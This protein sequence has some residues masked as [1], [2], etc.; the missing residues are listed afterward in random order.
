MIGNVVSHGRS[1]RDAR[2]LSA[3][4]LKTEQNERVA[5]R[6]DN[7]LATDLPASLRDMQLMRDGTRADA[8]FLHIS[9][10]PGRQMTDA[11][12]HRAGDIVLRHL[13][14][15]EHGCAR[16]LHDKPRVG[17]EG[18]THLHLVVARVGP[19]GLVVRAGLDKIRVETACRLAE[20]ELGE[21]PTLGRH[22]PSALRFFEKNRPEVAAWL[23]AG[24]GSQPER[25][26]SAVTPDQ[27]RVLDRKQID[28]RDVRETVRLALSQ[29]DGPQALRAALGEAGLS[30]VAGDKAG[31]WIVQR[32][33]EFV[34]ALDRLAKQKRAEVSAFM[35]KQHV[36]APAPS[37]APARD[38]RH[39]LGPDQ[40]GGPG[41]VP[42]ARPRPDAGTG[43]AAG[44]PGRS[45]REPGAG[46]LGAGAAGA[47]LPDRDAAPDRRPARR[48]RNAAVEVARAD[49]QPRARDLRAAAARIAAQASPAYADAMA[50]LDRRAEAARQRMA[51]ASVPLEPPAS[52]AEARKKADK[53]RKAALDAE[54]RE[55]EAKA[56]LAAA[57][58]SRPRGVLAWVTGKVAVADRQI[59]ALEKLA[60]ERTQDARTRR[61][62][63]DSD[64]RG[65]QR[66]T[67]AFSDAEAA[68]GRRQEGEQREARMDLARVDH[69]RKAMEARPEWAVQGVPALEEH[70][71]R[72]EAVRRADE[73]KLR[74]QERR[75]QEVEDRAY[76]P[77]GPSR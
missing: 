17:G 76:T 5:V 73:A 3:H 31:A 65:E 69:L 23:T 72:A 26:R 28:F 59:L 46:D 54:R 58:A 34:G 39:D 44:E 25:P 10:S 49:C 4:L 45:G 37:L 61:S 41:R 77:R 9:I 38:G 43:P 70:M 7:M 53:A 14:M 74:E 75:Q 71:R 19:D 12:V 68:H 62:I 22:H 33:G 55:D 40:Q 56:K 57:E 27:R 50:E 21:A 20:F 64:V 47:D 16:V 52:L 13:G 8:A 63:R 24:L 36:P 1:G 42:D 67:R 66:E 15:A 29:S 11:E 35:E 6:I 32:D 2:N 30:V 48:A 60:S 18:G 51:R